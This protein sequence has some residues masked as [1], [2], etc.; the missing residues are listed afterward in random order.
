MINRTRFALIFLCLF[1][2][3]VVSAPRFVEAAGPTL[4]V[5]P[6]SGPA[7]TVFTFTGSGFSP[8]KIINIYA[9]EPDGLAAAGCWNYAAPC[10]VK[11]SETG[12]ISFSW[13]SDRNSI[14]SQ[15]LGKYTWVARELKIGADPVDAQASV[16]VTSG[17]EDV[18]SGAALN[19]SPSAGR[20]FSFSGSGFVP[21]E[22]V[23]A[24]LTYPPNCSSDWTRYPSAAV[25]V[26]FPSEFAGAVGPQAIK[27]TESG[28]IVFGVSMTSFDGNWH[29]SPNRD[30]Y[31]PPGYVYIIENTASCL[32]RYSMSVRSL[33][34]GKGAIVEF[35]V[36]GNP[37]DESAKL[38]VEAFLGAEGA[39]VLFPVITARGSK[40]ASNEGINCW[41][42]RPDGG[43]YRELT[44]RADGDG[45][46]T[47]T[48]PVGYAWFGPSTEEPGQW[49]LTCR[50]AASDRFGVAS[51]YV[52]QPPGEPP[53]KEN[54]GGGSP[55]PTPPEPIPS[56]EPC[57]TCGLPSQGLP[58]VEGPTNP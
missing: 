3:I 21:G 55:K 9:V 2:V 4:A 42:T 56:P 35:E 13:R 49:W 51:F 27:V 31:L 12:S 52:G 29:V 48:W 46:F 17:G 20:Q 16:M 7:G 57:P 32:G 40:Y 30:E 47:G 34:S 53:S 39:S 43:A 10:N 22:I 33:K 5:A 50:G 19:V 24:W 58:G 41:S 28:S 1:V 18:I 23:N 25:G 14:R 8:N 26:G 11:T 37:I 44:F 15:A 6:A 38:E 54:S 36:T 45:N